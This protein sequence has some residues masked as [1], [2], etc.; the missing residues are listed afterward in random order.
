[1]LDDGFTGGTRYFSK[2]CI[3][4]MCTNQ[5]AHLG[6]QTGLGWELNQARYMGTCCSQSTNRENGI[7]RLRVHVRHAT[8]LRAGDTFELH[9]PV[10][11]NPTPGHRRRAT[12]HCRYGVF[13]DS[14]LT[15]PNGGR[16]VHGETDV[17]ETR[18]LYRRGLCG[19]ANDGGN[20]AK[21]P[22]VKVTVVD[23]NAARIAAWESDDLPIFEPGLLD[24]V[25]KA[26]AAIYSSRPTWTPPYG[27]PTSCSSP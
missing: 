16:L 11:K 8:P 19:R 18:Y 21:C 13:G 5:V 14:A 10:Q 12:G 4:Q 7:Y 25:K 24:V 2:D 20:R 27:R 3:E 6:L 1:M 22:D 23:I 26:R 15:P 17:Q 9:V